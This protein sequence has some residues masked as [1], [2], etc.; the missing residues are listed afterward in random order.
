MSTMMIR[1]LAAPPDSG[2][3]ATKSASAASS[4]NSAAGS[5]LSADTL[6]TEFLQLL[7][8]QLKNQD[9]E[10]PMDGTAFVTQLAQFTSVQQETQSTSDLNLMLSLMERAASSSNGNPSNG[11]ASGTEASGT[12]PAGRAT[13]GSTSGVVPIPGGSGEMFPA[14]SSPTGAS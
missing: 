2:A 4:A 12:T 11:A 3:T 14:G 5:A 1:P 9:P 6:S 7:I 13:N 8:A 10:N